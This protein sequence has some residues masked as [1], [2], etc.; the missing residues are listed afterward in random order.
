MVRLFHRRYVIRLTDSQYAHLVL[1]RVLIDVEVRYEVRLVGLVEV[2]EAQAR[3][4]KLAEL[5][6]LFL[7]LHSRLLAVHVWLAPLQLGKIGITRVS[8]LLQS[9][10]SVV[11]G[12]REDGALLSI[13]MAAKPH[14]LS[15]ILVLRIQ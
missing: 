5:R 3:S 10:T 6:P 14:G 11:G 8:A 4:I 12:L 1:L 15:S 7:D 13:Q 2:A 9:F